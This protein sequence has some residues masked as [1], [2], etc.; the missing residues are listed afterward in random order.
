[1]YKLLSSLATQNDSKIVLVVM[2]GLGDIPEKGTPLE[3]AHTPNLDL[4]AAQGVTGLTDP[5]SPGITPGSGPA[6]MA[7][8]GYDPFEFQI[9]RGVLEALG[10]DVELKEGDVAARANFA[11]LS[12]SGEVL[13]RRAGRIPTSKCVEL[14]GLLQKKIP[15]IDG[16]EIVVRPGKEHRFCVVFRGEGLSDKIAE[17]DPQK[18]GHRP[19][20]PEPLIW[21]AERTSNVVKKFIHSARELL[22]NEDA[23]NFVLLR[24]YA[25]N[26]EILSL[27]TLYKIKPAAIATYPMYRGIAK[28]VGMS[29]LETGET[30]AEEF[31]ALKKNYAKYDFFYF[32]IKGT[33]KAGEDGNSKEKKEV[34]EEFDSELNSLLELN[35]E[36]V[37]VTSD[38]STPCELKSHSWHPNPILLRSK[39]G[40]VDEV[41]RFTERNCAKGGL[42]RISATDVMALMLANALKFKKFGA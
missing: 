35:P 32:H 27:G 26:P 4:L 12:S 7:L 33:D 29:V 15:S 30:I 9:G 28:L 10:V 1:M 38:H 39:Y 20:E 36:C 41:T 23:A 14:T 37:V 22:K 6:H 11:T 19:N 3:L 34:I 16:V 18:E 21:E 2:D 25:E 42:G 13:D 40:G 8:F 31:D 17:T 24:G 5:I